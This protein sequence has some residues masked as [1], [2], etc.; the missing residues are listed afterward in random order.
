MTSSSRSV[1]AKMRWAVT[2]FAGE[3][4]VQG[5]LSELVG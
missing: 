2:G 3:R 4:D 1:P 5:G